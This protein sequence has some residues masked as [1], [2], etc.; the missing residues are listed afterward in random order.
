MERILTQRAS[1]GPRAASQP[2]AA[3]PA[4][5]PRPRLTRSRHLPPRDASGAVC[6]TVE[7]AATATSEQRER[8]RVLAHT[9]HRRWFLERPSPL[10]LP[11]TAPSL[12]TTRLSAMPST[13]TTAVVVVP[14]ATAC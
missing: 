9:L 8:F 12:S 6:G 2:V 5:V 13:I 11:L 4:A 3:I 14:T 1:A 10:N 7:I